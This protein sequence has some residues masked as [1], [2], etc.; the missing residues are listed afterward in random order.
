[1]KISDLLSL[2]FE[3]LRRRKGRTTLTIIG[4]VVGTCSIVV[5]VSLGIAM[6]VGFDEMIQQWGDLT[7][8]QVYNWSNSGSGEVEPLNDEMVAKIDGFDHVVVATPQYQPRYFSMSLAAG[9]NDRYE[10]Q[11]VTVV[12]MYPKAIE[13]LGYE[14]ESGSYLPD[15]PSSSSSGKKQIQVLIG[16]NLG[17]QFTD[18]KKRGEKA[19]RY[20]GQTDAMGNELGPFVDIAKDKIT[21]KSNNQSG[22]EGD[23]GIEYTLDVEGIMISDY[24]KGY[25]TDS[26]VVMD[27][28]VLKRLEKEYMKANGI[29][30]TN[31][32][33]GYDNVYVKVD[34]VDNVEA[35]EEAIQELGYSTYSMRSERENMQKQSQMIQ[36]ILGGLGAVSLFVAALS[37]ANT[38]TMAI[39]ERTKEIGVMKVLGCGLGKIRAMFLV[40]AAMIG[41]LG[42]VFGVAISYAISL[43]LNTFGPLLMG[44]VL[45]SFLPMYGSKISVIPAWLALLGISFSTA[46]GIL[47]GIMPA[48]RAVKI[49]ALEAIRHE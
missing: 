44:S 47:S 20:Q 12:G 2:C 14:L 42:G 31:S 41:F 39:Y 7:Q 13:L 49:S 16:Q 26:G 46:I 37:I 3:N 8:I 30:D 9:K 38:M 43:A 19:Y 32:N 17:Y 18:T 11:Y 5:M 45:G 48:G 10:A 25:V 22:D 33:S 15:V 29:K 6:N 27:L 34:D 23:K 24:K 36:M 40:E 28:T 4:V 21:L 35:V 1:M